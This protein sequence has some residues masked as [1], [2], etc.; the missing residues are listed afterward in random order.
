MR[1]ARGA[2]ARRGPLL[3]RLASGRLCC[4][5]RPPEGAN[6]R[7]PVV[8]PV[9]IDQ[10]SAPRGSAAAPRAESAACRKFAESSATSTEARASECGRASRE[11]VPAFSW[12]DAVPGSLIPMHRLVLVYTL[13][14]A[15]FCSY[16]DTSATPQSAS[17][18]ALR[19]ANLRRDGKRLRFYFFSI[20]YLLFWLSSLWFPPSPAPSGSF[21]RTLVA[22][23]WE[24]VQKRKRGPVPA[25]IP[26]SPFLGMGLRVWKAVCGR[27]PESPG[28]SSPGP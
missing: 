11:P 8:C 16:R 6:K 7:Q 14:C 28:D 9:I 15:N 21:L 27:R 10:L 23:V 13:V 3:L 25:S 26:E 24:G 4:S 1:T 19:N 12:S 18:K 17:I 20:K 5:C 22:C 2:A